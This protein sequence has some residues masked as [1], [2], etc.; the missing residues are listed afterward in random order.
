MKNAFKS[1]FNDDTSL[2]D[3]LLHQCKTMAEYAFASGLKVPGTLLPPLEAYADRTEDETE[4]SSE[5]GAAPGSKNQEA[6]STATAPSQL[7]NKAQQ[8]ARIHAQ[9][10]DIVAPAKPRTILLLAT[11]A[12]KGGFW[13]FLGPVRL[14]RRMMVTAIFCLIA[15]LSISL[16][17]TVDGNPDK[18]SLLHNSGSSLFL[19]QLFLLSAAGIGASF[20]ALF[21][22]A[23]FVREVSFDPVYEA[24]YWIRFVLGLIAGIMLATLI[25]IDSVT[26]GAQSKSATF[27][28]LGQPVLALLGG[29]SATLVY[30][31]L[32]RLVAAVESLVRG[33]TRDLAVAQEQ[34]LKARFAEQSV[35]N[36]LRLSAELAALQQKLSASADPDELRRELDR[37]QSD[38]I[39]PGSYDNA[40]PAAPARAQIAAKDDLKDDVKT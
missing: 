4:T 29:F 3:Q 22:A 5:N 18:F 21:M 33:D 23:R 28:G 26:Q 11:E 20:S 2:Q 17:P 30:R 24:S 14:I 34:Q 6:A 13:Q 8:L 27:Q 31:V 36:R 7:A 35:Q 32:N 25:P 9:L 12:S 10:V 15:L 38:L 37:I 16:S 1:N 39:I 19:N 40:T